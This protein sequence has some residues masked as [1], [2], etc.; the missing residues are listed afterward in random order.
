MLFS[1]QFL[2]SIL[3]PGTADRVVNLVLSAVYGLFGVV[4]FIGTA[5]GPGNWSRTARSPAS[6]SCSTAT[7]SRR[8]PPAVHAGEPS[9]RSSPAGDAGTSSR[10][11]GGIQ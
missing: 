1:I 11:P 6:T 10:R 2:S 9:Q 3:L 4:L 7:T 8:G 5:A